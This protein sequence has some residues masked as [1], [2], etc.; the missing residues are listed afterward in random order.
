MNNNELSLEEAL[1]I[2][3]FYS[4]LESKTVDSEEKA[5]TLR[6]SIKLV[7]SFCEYENIGICADN[8]KQAV[9]SLKNYLQALGYKKNLDLTS[10]KDQESPV[11]IKFNTQTMSYY[12][13]KY[14]GDY[15]GVLISC[16]A[17][18]NDNIVGTYGHFPLNLFD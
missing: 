12:L 6:H 16:Y 13:D 4:S 7:T 11:Y 8:S 17:D 1:K 14:L 15:R 9:A 3:R 10:T 18:E 2:L 5:Q